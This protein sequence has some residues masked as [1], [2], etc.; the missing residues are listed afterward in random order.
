MGVVFMFCL[1]VAR[2]APN[3]GVMPFDDQLLA[4]FADSFFGYG[5]YRGRVWFVGM[6]EGGGDSF[7]ELN[8]RFDVWRERGKQELEDLPA[9]SR[10]V[11]VGR[12]FEDRPKL[13]STWSKLIRLYLSA[14]ETPSG[15][16]AVREFQRARLGRQDGDI[17]LLELLPLPSPSTSTIALRSKRT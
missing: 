13:Q 3:H 15:T 16:D 14:Y 17:A 4:E 8:R 1:A 10:L 2:L 11:G 5:D 7:E 9:Y 12:W 6:E